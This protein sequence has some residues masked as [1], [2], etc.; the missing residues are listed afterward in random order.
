[1]STSTHIITPPPSNNAPNIP[2]TVCI[3]LQSYP[4]LSASNPS[5][6]HI[7][8]KLPQVVFS[9]KVAHAPCVPTLVTIQKTPT[10]HQIPEYCVTTSLPHHNSP[11]SII[12]HPLH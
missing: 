12:V 10:I 8:A 2:Y 3:S 1:M 11:F 4:L 9:Q 6:V 5:H 7:V